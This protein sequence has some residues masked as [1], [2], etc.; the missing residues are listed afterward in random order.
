MSEIGV[1][2]ENAAMAPATKKKQIELELL[3]PA[4]GPE[5]LHAAL[6]AG[7]DSVYLGLQK[8][9]ARTGA[10]NFT[11]DSLAAAVEE[12]KAKGA[13]VY[14][15]LNV[16]V[17]QRELGQAARCLEVARQAGVSAVL[18]RDPALLALKEAFPDLDFHFST[19]T[20]AT[21]GAD[22]LAAK[23]LGIC[24]IVLAR[25]MSLTEIAKASAV[26]DVETEVFVQG[27][28]CFCVSGRCLLSSWVGG[29][30]GNRGSCASPCRAFWNADEEQI[31]T[32]FSMH[33]LSAIR[34]LDEIRRA[35]AAAIKIEGRLKN[36][37]WVGQAVSAYRRALE[38]E[39][40]DLLAEECESLGAYAGR[41]S[42]DGYLDGLRKELTGIAGREAFEK[43]PTAASSMEEVTTENA[44]TEN[45][46]E[47]TSPTCESA[48]ADSATNAETSS[49]YDFYMIAGPKGLECRCVCDD[50]EE[51]W[52]IPKTVVHRV[53]K[54]I[55]VGSLFERLEAGVV[56]GRTLGEG[57][58]DVPDLLLPPR[59]IN[60]LIDSIAGVIRRAEKTNDM[61][62][63]DLP[64]NVREILQPSDPHPAN[65]WEL[66][67]TPNR[68]RIEAR[69]VGTFLNHVRVSSVV[70]E[71]VNARNF[72]SVS[73][74]CE[75]IRW[76]AAL[77][78]VFFEDDLHD[79]TRLIEVCAEKRLPVE[80]NSWG[81]W[82]LAK[83][84]GARME[85]GPGLAVLN[86]LAA[87]KLQELGLQLVTISSEAD[88]RQMENLAAACPAPCSL[89]VFG[90]PPLFTSR[91]GLPDDL[92]RDVLSDRRGARLTTKKERGLTIFRPERPFDLRDL[93][94]ARIRVKYLTVDL[95]GSEDPVADWYAVPTEEDETFRFNYDRTLA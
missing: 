35:G 88:R 51:K 24:R 90:R 14:L 4:G 38:G 76:T 77:P 31:G 45:V 95:V 13:K 69:H 18:V 30:S 53:K 85:G 17:A 48:S 57:E 25:E 11:P 84:C 42:T 41:N 55:A 26:A 2:M 22:V 61:L 64:E 63:L 5:P 12:A 52:S 15:T 78:P 81:A 87:K 80:V 9:N 37:A 54:A 20:G 27:A 32:P 60:G 39:N 58:T 67:A 34:R 86:S 8:L 28:L 65:Q 6:E 46:V 91:V 49:T 23:D 68:V 83:Q 21:S 43:T 94:N 40:P 75:G 47:E 7:A 62:R 36:A 56:Q 3:A 59:A 70:I 73:K 71:G 82:R 92:L 19:Q 72:A 33:D 66:G 10:K 16:D 79:V 29:R 89:T 93:T 74:T 1:N 44:P 50:R